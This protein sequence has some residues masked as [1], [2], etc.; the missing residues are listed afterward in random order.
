[1][2][3]GYN[4][5]TRLNANGV[6][7]SRNFDYKWQ[8]SSATDKGS[9]PFSEPE[10]VILRDWLIENRDAFLYINW[11]NMDRNSVN[12]TI[13]MASYIITPNQDLIKIYSS[14]I[15]RLSDKWRSQ[16]FSNF[17][18]KGN[19]A[20]GYDVSSQHLNNPNVVNWAYYVLGLK[21]SCTPEMTHHDPINTDKKYT[22]TVM[23]TNVEFLGN[24][25][26]AVL[27]NYK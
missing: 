10:A 3:S 11:H 24:F 27:D 9:A 23:E 2:S 14:V 25:I 6:N 7:I 15:R 21:M 17:A 18:N 8:E 22:K 1:M 20:Y 5:H 4:A 12:R 16:Y 26:L 19:V 13:E